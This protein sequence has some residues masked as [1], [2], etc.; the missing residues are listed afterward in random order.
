MYDDEGVMGCLVEAL[1]VWI[2]VN[3]LLSQ[4]L[5]E[6]SDDNVPHGML[7]QDVIH[8]SLGRAEQGS[9]LCSLEKR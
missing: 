8:F 6:R 4:P 3:R 5:V 7:F 1:V 2:V 9:A